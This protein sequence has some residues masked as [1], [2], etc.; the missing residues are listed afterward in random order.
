M[1]IPAANW[2]DDKLRSFCAALYEITSRIE[3]GEKLTRKQIVEI[4]RRAESRPVEGSN[5]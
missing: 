1:L 5:G 2:S 4:S 3:R